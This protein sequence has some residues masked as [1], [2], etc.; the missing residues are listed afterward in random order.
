MK[1]LLSAVLVV[2][3]MTDPAQADERTPSLNFEKCR[4]NTERFYG[5]LGSTTVQIVGKSRH[6]CVMLY[7]TEIESPFWD[8]FLDS[9]CVVPGALGLVSFEAQV[10]SGPDLS[11][12]DEYCVGMPAVLE[13]KAADEYVHPGEVLDFDEDGYADLDDNCPGEENPKQIDTDQDGVGDICDLCR[14]VPAPGYSN[15]CPEDAELPQPV[16]SFRS[17]VSGTVNGDAFDMVV[18]RDGGRERREIELGEHRETVVLRR[19]ERAV[20]LLSGDGAEGIVLRY[21]QSASDSQ[22]D[23]P[24]GVRERVSRLGPLAQ[25]VK[26]AAWLVHVFRD[27]PEDEALRFHVHSTRY[28]PVDSG[29]FEVSP[30]T[31][32]RDVR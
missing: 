21:R 23:L 5:G 11:S 8:G 29:L 25:P 1:I 16:P 3:A 14:T 12:L 18:W 17:R 10:A 24:E 4:P 2:V 20:Y 13:K 22:S 15:G 26:P 9:I 6:G 32:I 27:R 30:E 31:E 7:G 19:D 28:E